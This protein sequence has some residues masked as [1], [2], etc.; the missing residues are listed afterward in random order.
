MWW[1]RIRLVA[2][3][4]VGLYLARMYVSMGIV[5]FDPDGFWTP[6]FERWGYPDWLRMA[7]GLLETAGGPLLLVP[8]LASYAGVA[9]TLV[10]GGAWV[11]RFMDG[12]MV[13]VAWITV[14]AVALLWVAFEWRG[15][16]IPRSLRD[17]L[18]RGGEAGD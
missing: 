6:A 17:R 3:W 9:L 13:D 4:L 11:T 7:V 10:M 5:K 16:V 18:R 14:Y 12:R 1:K 8:W 15:F 2:A